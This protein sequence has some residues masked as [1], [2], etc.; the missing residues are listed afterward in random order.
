MATPDVGYP[1]EVV[2]PTQKVMVVLRNSP[3]WAAIIKN[4][5]FKPG[6]IIPVTEEQLISLYED[7]LVLDVSD[8]EAD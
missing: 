4:I 3:A 7:T 2:L 5:P 6:Q 1:A 8:H